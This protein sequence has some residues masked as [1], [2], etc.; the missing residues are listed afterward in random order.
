MLMKVI[1]RNVYGNELIYPVCDTSRM[2]AELT[3]QKTFTERDI[4]LIKKLGYVVEVAQEQSALLG[5][6]AG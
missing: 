3:R 1:I 2:L 5:R 6:V 4:A